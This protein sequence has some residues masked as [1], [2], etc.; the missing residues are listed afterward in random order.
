MGENNREIKQFRGE[1]VK[2]D[3][4]LNEGIHTIDTAEKYKLMLLMIAQIATQDEKPTSPEEIANRTYSFNV[5]DYI[6]LKQVKD[7]YFMEDY[8]MDMAEYLRDNSAITITEFDDEG[9]LTR[10]RTIWIFEDVDF[11]KTTN[12]WKVVYKFTYSISSFLFELRNKF[13]AYHLKNIMPM[14]S[15]YSIRLYELLKQYEKIGERTFDIDEFREKIGTRVFVIDKKTKK[16]KLLSDDYKD[17]LDLRR[18]VIEKAVEEVNKYTDIEITDVEYHR[19]GRRI[20]FITFYFKPKIN[21]DFEKI[22]EIKEKVE[23]DKNEVLQQSKELPVAMEITWANIGQLRKHYKDKVEEIIRY[24]KELQTAKSLGNMKK[25]AVIN[26]LTENEIL[27]LLINAD[28]DIYDDDMVVSIIKK[29]LTNKK[30]KNPMGFLVDQLN[31]NMKTAKFKELT[32][33]AKKIDEELFKKKLEDMFIEGK[34]AIE[35]MKA[36]WNEKVKGKVSKE[37]AKLLRE[38]LA[39]AIYD[40]LESVVYI[41]APDEVYKDWLD[42]NFLEDIRQFLRDRFDVSDVVVEIVDFDEVKKNSN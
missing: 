23:A 39:N 35:F 22:E 14:R 8:V 24:I 29:A 25:G 16:K 28:K 2:K 31:I 33:T 11:K 17:F 41:P 40:E 34:P 4:L 19:K 13:I 3:N 26:T 37:I 27:F 18:R 6:N 1:I 36:Y 12:G 10:Y 42:T 7:K 20:G 5:E 15:K 38:P 32:L 9:R 30:L 21:F